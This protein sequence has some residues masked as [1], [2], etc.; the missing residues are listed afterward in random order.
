MKCPDNQNISE[1]ELTQL[2]TSCADWDALH[3]NPSRADLQHRLEQVRAAIR[4]YHALGMDAPLQWYD[5]EV[6][7]FHQWENKVTT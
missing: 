5:E 4:D 7:R 1:P 6:E 3:P 2:H